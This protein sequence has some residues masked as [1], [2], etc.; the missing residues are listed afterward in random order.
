MSTMRLTEGSGNPPLPP[1]PT[2]SSAE[3]DAAL[4][5]AVAARVVKMGLAT[6]AVFFLESTKPLSYVGSQALVFLEPFVKSV[7]TLASYDRFTAMVEDRKNIETLILRIEDL[8]ETARAEEKAQKKLEK[9]RKKQ[10]SLE[11][12]HTGAAVRE[13]S[14]WLARLFRRSNRPR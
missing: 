1:G 13:D 10:E 3:Q 2:P 9:E 12:Q 4:I 8:D 7:L 6:P 11:R 14:G 5:E